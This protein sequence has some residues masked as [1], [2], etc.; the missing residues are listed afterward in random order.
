FGYYLEVTKSNR[1]L[2]PPEWDRRQTLVGAE[3]YVTPELKEREAEI[4]GAEEKSQRLEYELFLEVR[5]RLALAGARLRRAGESLALVD[6]LAAFAA[7]ATRE[8]WV[9]PLIMDGDRIAVRGGRHPVVEASLPAHEF[10]PNDVYL[11]GDSH[12]ILVITGPNMAGKS[13]YLRQGALLV[14]LAQTGSFRPAEGAGTGRAASALS[15]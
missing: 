3:R 2:V 6:V 4:L 10:V 8:G 13:T 1:H 11:N 9:R 7:L 14:I 12:Q 5:S 15:R